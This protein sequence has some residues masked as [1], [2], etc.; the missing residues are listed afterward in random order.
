MPN[1]G[2]KGYS[3]V[4]VDRLDSRN[5][6]VCTTTKVALVEEPQ[7]SRSQTRK[8]PAAPFSLVCRARLPTTNYYYYYYYY[9]CCTWARISVEA[10]LGQCYWNTFGLR[11]PTVIAPRPTRPTQMLLLLLPIWPLSSKVEIW[12]PPFPAHFLVGVWRGGGLA[13]GDHWP[14]ETNYLR[15]LY[16]YYDNLLVVIYENWAHSCCSQNKRKERFWHTNEWLH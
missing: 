12:T 2:H 4:P 1:F 6:C 16:F 15:K 13:E 10:N 11:E 3:V 5:L 7:C 9:G 8:T 14:I